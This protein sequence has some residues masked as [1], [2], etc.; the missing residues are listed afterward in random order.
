MKEL[1]VGVGAGDGRE[2]GLSEGVGYEIVGVGTED[3]ASSQDGHGNG[4]VAVRELGKASLGFELV[5]AVQEAG[6]GSDRVIFGEEVGVVGMRAIDGGAAEIEDVPDIGGG[7]GFEDVVC[8]GDVDAP[9]DLAATA[10]IEEVGEV[11]DGV[12]A[13]VGEEVGERVSDVLP[14]KGDA[15]GVVD[16]GGA[17]VHRQ[18]E[19]DAF[20]RTGGGGPACCRCNRMRR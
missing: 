11:D 10:G 1:H 20:R 19:L 2:Q 3:R 6:D 17:N 14:D 5:F 4:R 15:V 12:D 18:N 9:G 7:A 16:V 13:V 8:A